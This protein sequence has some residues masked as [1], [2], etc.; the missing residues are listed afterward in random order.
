M[1]LPYVRLLLSCALLAAATVS[2]EELSTSGVLLDRVAAVVNDGI[3]LQSDLDQQSEVIAQRIQQQGQQPPPRNV[4]RQ[5]VLE[6]LVLQELQ[7]QRADRLGIQITDEMLNTALTDVAE[8]NNI[9]FSDLPAALEQQGVD[10][11]SYRDEM[12]KEMMMTALRQRD[13]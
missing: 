10:Y 4:L 7:L 12:R 9:K 13:V 6:R 11:R 5:Q 3:V 8:R 1:A 2:A